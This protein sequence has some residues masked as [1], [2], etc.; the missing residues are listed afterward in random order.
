M[1]N[2]EE[3]LRVEKIRDEALYVEAR[4]YVRGLYGNNPPVMLE[5]AEAM[6]L[7]R[8]PKMAGFDTLGFSLHELAVMEVAAII[9]E[10]RNSQWELAHAV[11]EEPDEELDDTFLSPLKGYGQGKCESPNEETERRI[12]EGVIAPE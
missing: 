1:K 9:V 3:A 7:M 10:E 2:K 11:P 4:A 8:S 6:L 5:I 12:Q